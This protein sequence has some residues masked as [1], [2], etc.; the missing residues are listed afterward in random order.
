V[1]IQAGDH[2]QRGRLAN[3]GGGGLLATTEVTAS[4]RMLARKVDLELRLDS[5]ASE[6]LRLT[7]RILRIGANS[8]A[9]GFDSVPD[10][11]ERLFDQISTAS[12]GHR[13][14][15]SVV[16]IDATPERRLPIAEAF[17]AAGC[18]VVDVATPLEAIVRLGESHFE[19]DLIA[20]GNSL[21]SGSSDELHRFVEREHPRA[22]LV[23]IG[24]ELIEPEGLAHWLSSANPGDDLAARLREVLI[25]PA[26]R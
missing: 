12:H 25:N 19:P 17:R 23:T 5:Q 10:S 18:A 26:R 22:K 11:F 3:L 7:G 14:I 2:A 8:V 6:W 9:V 24:D 13:R 4:E 21:P 1:I 20:I 15:L 16:L